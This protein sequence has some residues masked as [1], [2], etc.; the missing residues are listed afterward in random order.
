MNERHLRT[1]PKTYTDPYNRHRPHRSPHQ[2]SPQ[3]SETSQTAPVIPFGGRVRRTRLLGGPI[4]EH[5][6]AA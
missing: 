2:R 3:A 1:D 5:Q 6:Q 4:N